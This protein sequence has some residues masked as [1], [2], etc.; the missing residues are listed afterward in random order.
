MLDLAIAGGGPAGM[1]AALL[2]ARA[3]LGVTVFEKHADFLRDFRGDTVHPSTL[4]IFHELGLLDSLLHARTSRSRTLHA[5]V[6]GQRLRIIDFATCRSPRRSSPSCRSGTFSTSSPTRHDA[7]PASRYADPA[8][9][10]EPARG[11]G[12]VTGVRLANGRGGPRRLV[13]AADGRL[14]PPP[15]SSTCRSRDIGAPMDVFWFRLPRRPPRTTTRP[16][17]STPGGS[18]S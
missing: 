8:R 13:I 7:I 17:S 14:P 18:S 16:A 6:A 1:V 4:Q 2:F 10:T 12:R 15:R 3:G 5:R 9:S 11:N